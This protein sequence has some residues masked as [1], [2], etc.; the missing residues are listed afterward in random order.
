M[1][2]IRQLVRYAAVSGI[3]TGVSQSV[4]A[5]LVATRATSAVTANIVATMI[6][7]IPSFE[8]NRRWVWGKTGR[9]SL[10]TEVVPF[11]VISACGLALSTLAVAAASRWADANGLD[12]TARTLTVQAANLSAFGL[13]WIAQ[14]VLLDRVLFRRRIPRKLAGGTEGALSFDV[15]G[16][17]HE[18]D[19]VCPSPLPAPLH[20]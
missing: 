12:I 1:I 5:V 13:V 18:H 3:S 4:L 16:G 20:R 17:V 7:T 19:Y 11:A 10:T 14:F 6:G 15:E 2:R 8:L 9:R